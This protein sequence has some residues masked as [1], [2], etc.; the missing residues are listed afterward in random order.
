MSDQMEQR[1]DE[2]VRL[3]ALSLRRTTKNQTEAILL[4][5]RRGL[6]RTVSR[7]WLER[8]QRP[9]AR[10]NRGRRGRARPWLLTPR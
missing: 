5:R 7:S 10:R 3:L 8:P 2:I 1:L 9:F 4:L 6:I